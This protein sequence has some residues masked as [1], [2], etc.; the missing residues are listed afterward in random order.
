MPLGER[1]I[2]MQKPKTETETV[3]SF[4]VSEDWLAVIIGLVLVL[5]V[6][7]GLVERIPWP[8]LGVLG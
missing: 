3:T 4:K 7:I 6:W 5:I 8:L 2:G 1:R